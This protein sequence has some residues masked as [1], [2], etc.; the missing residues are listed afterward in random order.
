MVENENYSCE[1]LIKRQDRQANESLL[2]SRLE[3]TALEETLQRKLEQEKRLLMDRIR[4]Q[5][6]FIE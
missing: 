3:K 5:D 6:K 1:L 4:S 2:Q